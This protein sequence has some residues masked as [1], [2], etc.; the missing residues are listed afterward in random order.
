MASPMSKVLTLEGSIQG[1]KKLQE[2]TSLGP[3]GYHFG[4]ITA[5]YKSRLLVDFKV[6]MTNL[7][8]NKE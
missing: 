3:S 4:H 5:A 8:G 1:W 2:L 6:T 7:G